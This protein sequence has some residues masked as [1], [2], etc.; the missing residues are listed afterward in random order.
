MGGCQKLTLSMLKTKLTQYPTKK[1]KGKIKATMNVVVFNPRSL[2][3]I[4]NW[5]MQGKKRVKTMAAM[6]N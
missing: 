6:T 2:I 3:M 5:A 4:C 1:A